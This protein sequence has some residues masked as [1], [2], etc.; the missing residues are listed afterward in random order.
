MNGAHRPPSNC[1]VC[2]DSLA[3]T[4]LG[5]ESCGTE[6]SGA[7]RTC[8]FCAL[9][10]EE[11]ELLRVFLSSRGNTKDL[12]RHLQVSYPTARM[13]FDA[14][15]G[16]LGLDRDSTAPPREEVLRQLASGE[17]D[18]DEAARLMDS[19]GAREQL[20]PEPPHRVP[21][22]DPV[23]TATARSESSREPPSPCL[24]G[25]RRVPKTGD[26]GAAGTA[27][28]GRPGS[29]RRPACGAVVGSFSVRAQ[30]LVHLDDEDP[31]HASIIGQQA[32]GLSTAGIPVPASATMGAPV[33]S[34]RR[35]SRVRARR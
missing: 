5:C 34:F 8:E 20:P 31:C 12:A 1:P 26:P 29:R 27:R 28:S 4:R 9:T 23:G 14:L 3:L 7:F 33:T 25:S 18:V 30:L 15:L 35:L 19:G 10:D 24:R 16:R 11:R 17:I 22:Q 32:P 2:G 13:R 21:R 6:I